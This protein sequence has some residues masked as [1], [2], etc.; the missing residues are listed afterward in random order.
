MSGRLRDFEQLHL[1]SSKENV[2]CSMT[3]ASAT[4]LPSISSRAHYYDAPYNY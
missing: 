4:K 2:S 3:Q 1:L